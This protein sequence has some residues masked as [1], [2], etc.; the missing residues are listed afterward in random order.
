MTPVLD[1]FVG[2]WRVTREISHREGPDA[3]FEGWVHF[4]PDSAGLV[5]REEGELRI[6]GQPVIRA[7]RQYLWRAIDGGAID[8]AFDD[9]RPFH[10][11]ASGAVPNDRHYCDPDIYDVAYD[12]SAWPE[13][14]CHW[15]VKGPRKDYSMMSRYCR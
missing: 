9:G 4:T 14:A 5:Y 1:D 15:Q 6:A 10:R 8:V 3:R 12:F 7:E 13:W 2:S 11:I